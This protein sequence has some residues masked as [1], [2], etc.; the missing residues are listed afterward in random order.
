MPKRTTWGQRYSDDFSCSSHSLSTDTEPVVEK[1]ILG[2]KHTLARVATAEKVVVQVFDEDG[3]LGEI[4]VRPSEILS[5]VRKRMDKVLNDIGAS[6][7]YF[8]YSDGIPVE[9]DNEE[10]TR[11]ESCQRQ[12]GSLYLGFSDMS[13]D[14][15][16]EVRVSNSQLKNISNEAEAVVRTCMRILEGRHTNTRVAQIDLPDPLNPCLLF[17][18]NLIRA[19]A[20]CLNKPRVNWKLIDSELKELEKILKIIQQRNE[21]VL[22]MSYKSDIEQLSTSIEKIQRELDRRSNFSNDNPVFYVRIEKPRRQ[23]DSLLS[24]LDKTSFLDLCGE[25]HAKTRHRIAKFLDIDELE[26]INRIKTKGVPSVLS[27]GMFRNAKLVASQGT[28]YKCLQDTETIKELLAPHIKSQEALISVKAE[29]FNPNTFKWVMHDFDNWANDLRSTQRCFLFSGVPGC[30]KTTFSSHIVRERPRFVI[31]SHYL[32]HDDVTTSAAKVM[33]LGIVYQLS[34]QSIEFES[35][36]RTILIEKRLTRKQLLSQEYPLASLFRDFLEGPLKSLSASRDFNQCIVI[37]GIELGSLGG[38]DLNPILKAV[39]NFFYYLPPWLRLVITTRPQLSILKRLR[40]FNPKH[41]QP[42]GNEVLTDFKNYFYDAL[43]SAGYGDEATRRVTATLLAEKAGG[44]YVFGTIIAMKAHMAHEFNSPA[45]LED[46]IGL[47]FDEVLEKDLAI[48]TDQNNEFFWQVVQ[49]SLIAFQALSKSDIISLTGCSTKKLDD[50]LDN[51]RNPFFVVTDGIVVRFAQKRIKGWLLQHYISLNKTDGRITDDL[52]THAIDQSKYAAEIKSL[53]HYFSERILIILQQSRRGNHFA[54]PTH[55]VKH[56]VMKYGVEHLIKGGMESEARSVILDPIMLLER[57]TDFE[58]VLAD[59]E[60]FSEEDEF[61]QLVRRAVSLSIPALKNDPRQIVS[62]LVGRLKAATIEGHGNSTVQREAETFVG[63]LENQDYGFAWWCPVAP[64]WDQAEQTLVKKMKGHGGQVQCVDL[65][66]CDRLCA[67]ASWDGFV[68]VWDIVTGICEVEFEGTEEA[69]WCVHWDHL[70][71]TIVSGGADRIVRLWNFESKEPGLVLEGHE[72]CVF[73]TKFSPDS[74]LIA[75]G[76]KDGTIRIWNTS[77]GECQK[78]LPAVNGF[79]Y[80][81]SWKMNSDNQ[82]LCSGGTDNLVRVWDLKTSSCALV[83]KGHVDWVRSVC[84]SVNGRNIY[85]GSSD[86]TV[87]CWDASC[88][89]CDQVLMGHTGG[90]WD[91]AE[92]QDGR[93]IYSACV[94]GSIKTW[95]CPTWKCDQTL[96][97]HEGPVLSLAISSDGSK[98]TSGGADNCLIEWD[99]E[100][101]RTS[102]VLD[103]HGKPVWGLDLNADSSLIVS[104]SGDKTAR[105]WNMKTGL[106]ERVF[107]GHTGPVWSAKFSYSARYVATASSDHTAAIYR[108]ATGGRKW[109]LSHSDAV[110]DVVWSRDDRKVFTA[111]RDSVIRRWDVKKGECEVLLRGHTDETKGLSISPN[112]MRLA[113]ASPDVTIRVW[114]LS[115]NICTRVLQRKE[116]GALSVDWVDR[117]SVV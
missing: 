111:C 75:S 9:K 97:G 73:D 25:K 53:H 65:R 47:S 103:G 74:N 5:K 45:L 44:N 24:I 3:L 113:S 17:L 58:G 110:W 105:L 63:C 33:L 108:L 107:T 52:T 20:S 90:I 62:Q 23:I 36:I 61:I 60:M 40:V 27:S 50:L 42:K 67:T 15:G 14:S 100:V 8:Q 83:C 51:G 115:S 38:G 95:E 32:R 116:A 12:D 1:V 56:Y 117:K 54:F 85:S 91:V 112:G 71:K 22:L 39:R 99:C 106:V 6:F 46:Y 81:V 28:S 77:S 72:E 48:V 114:D 76:S 7:Y 11:V 30:G 102:T 69:V 94:D 29:S 68:R 19:I 89:E 93:Y 96:L 88:G 86:Q 70:G 64:T 10:N 87:I 59:L 43:T 37:D 98:L 31:A 18:K 57:A 21:F 13:D 78:V 84:W 2:M 35:K 55:T 80:S 82:Y 26:V 104:A 34:L 79:V 109:V 16:L 101:K 66:A 4:E 92:S 41:V 49:L